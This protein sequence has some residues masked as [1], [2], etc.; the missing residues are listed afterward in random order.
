MHFKTT[1]NKYLLLLAAFIVF[2]NVT[3]QRVGKFRQVV[4]PD[5]LPAN[6]V[7]LIHQDHLGF[8]W[9]GTENGLFRYDGYHVQ[10]FRNST[11]FP[12]L[13]PSNDI[14]CIAD[15]SKGYL[16]VGTK[17]GLCR[18]DLN[19]GFT[20]NYY[21]N[22]FPNSNNIHC[23]L[24]TRAG[25]LW[26][27]SEGG[28]YLYD[29]KLDKFTL[30]CDKR[31][32]SKV[33]HASITSLLVD[34]LGYI[35][36]GT[37]DK[38]LYR[39][40]QKRGIF[41]EM[42]SFNDQHSA[43]SVIESNGVLWVGT[44]GSGLYRIDNPYDTGKPLHFKAYTT[45]NTA[46]QLCSNVIWNI[47]MDPGSGM[48][49]AGTGNGLTCVEYNVH[50]NDATFTT[51]D[52]DSS[53][54]PGFFGKGATG[55]VFDGSLMMA[56]GADHGIA[57]STMRPSPFKLT[58][59]PLP[60]LYDDHLTSICTM[61]NG[62]VWTG[63]QHN[64]ILTFQPGVS[65]MSRHIM[66]PSCVEC[67]L[68]LSQQDVL[69]GTEHDGLF[70]I[71][72][73]VV[74]R[75]MN[76]TNCKYLTDNCIYSLAQDKNGNLL[77]G[78]Y[79]GLSILYASG[80]GVHL[81]T[82][83]TEQLADAHISSI[84]IAPNGDIWL[85]T[86]GNGIFRLRGN[87]NKPNTLMLQHYRELDH[88][89][90][91]IL[92]AY[93][94][95]ADSK[96]RVWACTKEAGLV[97]YNPAL[98]RMVGAWNQYD[99]PD[100]DAYSIEEANDGALW[101]SMRNE[102]INLRLSDQD[103]IESMQSYLRSSVIDDKFFTPG[104]SSANGP[105]CITF[106]YNNGFI[107]LPDRIAVDDS[108]AGTVY[109]TGV[110]VGNHPLELMDSLERGRIADK[111]PP[112]TRALTLSP[113]Q[114][115]FTLLFSSLNY[116][117]EKAERYAYK[118]DGYDD[119]WQYPDVE[120]R[121]A[122]Y[123]NL[124]YGTYKF[125][126]KS[127][128]SHGRWSKCETVITIHL[129]PPFYL[130]WYAFV[131]YFILLIV[132]IRLTIRYFK[133][134]EANR[135]QLQ[136]VRMEK[137]NI[138]QLNHKKL[139]FFTNITHDLMTPLT[140]ISSAISSLAQRYPEAAD[141]YRIINN[142]VNRLMRMLQQIL[143]FRKTETGNQ[144]LRVTLSS[145]TEF[146]R[147]EVESVAPLMLKKHIQLHLTCKPESIEG[148]FDSDKL[149]KI[150]YN[151]I[152]NATKY[153]H[154]GG[155]IWINVALEDDTILQLSVKDNGVGIAANKLPTLFKRFYEGEHR[156]FNTY[157]MGIGLS[158]V[159]DL[160]TLHHGTITVES[161]LGQGS[162]F[163]VRIP[164]DRNAYSDEEIDDSSRMLVDI[165]H[166]EDEEFK[167]QTKKNA[168]I[169]LIVED[170]EDL[171]LLLSRLLGATYNVNI[172]YNGQQALEM[173]EHSHPDLLITDMMMPVMDGLTLIKRVR[174]NKAFINM[175][176]LVL[177]AKHGDE[178]REEAY[179]A[180]SDAYITKPFNTSLLLTRVQNL[181][182]HRQDTDR[183]ITEQLF[184]GI[185]DTKISNSEREFLD[186]SI[187][188][189]H[190]HIA[191]PELDLQKFADEMGTSKSTLYKKLHALT[192]L[193]TSAFINAI[194]MR[195]AA[196]LLQKNP[197]ARISA[198]AYAVGFNDPK[199]F[200]SIFKKHFGVLPSDYAV[201]QHTDEGKNK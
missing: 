54:Y 158:L 187:G 169:I 121:S 71:H 173:L 70:L 38:G 68:Q 32:N 162:T 69:A 133:N 67:M 24:V 2:I 145:I 92:D 26:V 95:L 12:H 60:Y 107:S 1:N 55:F 176:I 43:Q 100:E 201:T 125:R 91:E 22:D 103:K 122:S 33:P 184:G 5:L 28:L 59:L 78:T 77:I 198:V 134:R 200:S 110:L 86:H 4:L 120:T 62:E 27:G 172:A 113:S 179:Q 195:S 17:M 94:L 88:S 11:L 174:A 138:E 64:G 25:H 101:I 191:D 76:M 84:S 66:L 16:W 56:I 65:V 144:H 36:I 73:G 189:V 147:G 177:T 175:P 180:G 6:E 170:N 124:P 23:M 111:M 57:M 49:W 72:N 159:K 142:N 61:L 127:T 149:D 157:G 143:E 108:H 156:K 97:V 196:E 39:Y 35:W 47:A 165:Q 123:S 18:F 119:E 114:R 46:G 53:P 105:G 82:K 63:L 137:K 40:N 166:P 81:R 139:Q 30:Y 136:M 112:Y 183:V 83:N 126:I 85:G 48:I 74:I 31:G 167:P 13:F 186:K 185:K 148:Y 153:N 171:L 21:F 188:I 132:L 117:E 41:Y 190:K 194:R 75:N 98:N 45:E 3:A 115:E 79:L 178:A 168:P 90:L 160:V 34:H 141:D 163:T 37:W 151:L 42:P 181:L 130:R 197:N 104:V 164:V 155:S 129:V 109:I 19:T 29:P 7:S 8:L 15:D 96:S 14:T 192:G 116:D 9:I 58:Q 118:L 80:Q 99:L 199:Y 146:V 161:Q 135:H 128:D 102:L 182:Q 154:D 52:N 140:V 51:I 150:I 50:T 131:V 193:G 87:I 106:G 20:K 10:R 44:W 93:K 152:S 89:G